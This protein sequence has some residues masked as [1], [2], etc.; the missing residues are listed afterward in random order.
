MTSPADHTIRT[1]EELEAHYI[2]RPGPMI[3]GKEIDHLNKGYSDFVAASTLIVMATRGADGGLDTSPRGGNP[4]FV[5][6]LDSKTLVIADRSGNNRLDSMRNLLFD[7]HISIMFIVPH[8]S[9]VLRL[10]GTAKISVDPKLRAQVSAHNPP[11]SLIIVDVQSVFFQCSM[12]IARSNIWHREKDH[13][14]VAALKP[15]MD[16]ITAWVRSLKKPK[17]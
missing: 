11:K 7:P 15:S 12:A 8:Y 10:Q 9:E 16:W 13:P 6:Q 4:G 17:A 5:R 3:V 14:S 2:E 1:V